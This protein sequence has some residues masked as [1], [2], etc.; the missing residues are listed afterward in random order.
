M[1]HSGVPLVHAVAQNASAA[2]KVRLTQAE[3]TRHMTEFDRTT[4]K[5]HRDV[6]SNETWL[7]KVTG[8]AYQEIARCHD[9]SLDWLH[10]RCDEYTRSLKKPRRYSYR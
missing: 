3:W 1:T 6:D 2:P 4:I 7:L 10:E 8:E 9:G 5:L